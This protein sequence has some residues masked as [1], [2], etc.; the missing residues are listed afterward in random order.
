MALLGDPN[1]TL[2]RDRTVTLDASKATRI[3]MTTPQP[4]EAT[5]QRLEYNRSM[6]GASWRDFMETQ[7]AY[8]SLW[9]QPVASKVTHGDFYLGARW[10][11]GK[12]GLGVATRTGEFSD[13]LRQNRVTPL[14]AGRHR[15]P[16]V[17]A[18][19]G[20]DSAYRGLLARGAAVVV[21]RSADVGDVAQA[22]AAARAGARLLLVVN[23]RIG[24]Q[25]LDYADDPTQLA[26]V[27]VG[28]LSPDEGDRLAHQAR[29]RGAT[30]T[31]E[32]STSSPYVYDL[33]R[34]WHNEI[35]RDLVVKG[36]ARNLARV[37]ETFVS[38]DP[39]RGGGEFRFDWPTYSAWGIGM[40]MRLP[41][42]SE[43]TDWVSTDGA[44]QWGQEAYVDS[45]L[46][47]IAPRTSYRPGSSQT[48]EWFK[49][50]TR[51]YLNDNYR[52][53]ARSG[54]RLSF[55]IPGYGGGARVGMS[56]DYD[57]SKETLALYQGT[58][59]L[60]QGTGTIVNA[61][62][63]S[64]SPLPY[65]LVVHT[66]RDASFSPYSSA[67]A[68][69]WTFTSRAP[70]DDGQDVLPLLQ[71]NWTL[72]TDKAGRATRDARFAVGIE[73]LE[74][75][76]GEGKACAPRVEASYDDG[77]SW[78][79]LAPARDHSFQ[80]DAPR[81]ADFVSLRVSARDTAGNTVTQTVTRAVGL[82]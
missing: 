4:T 43:R 81:R 24:R 33:M 67:T 35:P 46:Y 62:A 31:V 37:D 36:S 20:T 23:D 12:P 13:V 32:S 51:P 77:H 50:V 21:R 14:P 69:E 48:Q 6:G 3:E 70:R 54:D 18:G 53:P 76:V 55:D 7:T 63:P 74:G 30:V 16:L 45:L 60:A 10:R 15:L 1:V 72:A 80:L 9:A 66:T 39:T 22:L 5:Y 52:A 42:N 40:T 79:R 44:Y 49:P 38:P 75:A 68:T 61:T 59:Q 56:M 11:K 64:A 78:Q 25:Y 82:K 73:Q 34:T 2:D 28:M 19:D 71:P 17:Y 58:T 65:R 29:A 41:V 27:D 57:R 8:D 47:E 26:S